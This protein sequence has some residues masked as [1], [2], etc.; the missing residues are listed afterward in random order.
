MKNRRKVSILGPVL[1]IGV[2][3]LLLLNILGILEWSVWWNLL[4]FWPI[5]LIAAGL[6]LLIGRRSVL[7]ALIA[8]VLV[9]A[10]LAGALW[11]TTTGA[12]T[13]DLPSEQVRQSL[14]SATQA[15]VTIEPAVGILRLEALPESANPPW[16]PFTFGWNEERVWDLGLSPGAALQLKATLGAGQSEIDLTG[17][18]LSDLEIDMGVGQNTVILP[19]QGRFEVRI[20]GAVGVTEIVIPSGMAVRLQADTGLAGRQLPA[21]FREASDG[22]YT[23]PG[24]AAADNRV[25]LYANQAVGF[26]TIRTSE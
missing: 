2:G 10:L 26:L 5:L 14:G 1:L 6:D 8:T 24:Y 11:L 23:S 15:E 4:R 7:G 12:M 17:L 13:S 22:M 25:D 18:D 20:D 3:I 21:E 19:A 16:T 9:L